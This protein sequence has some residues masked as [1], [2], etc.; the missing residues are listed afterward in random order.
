MLIKPLIV[1]PVLVLI[2]ALASYAPAQGINSQESIDKIVGTPVETKTEKAED[3]LG[4]ILTLMDNSEV[5]LSEV[6]KRTKLDQLEIVYLQDV[7]MTSMPEAI[8]KKQ[9]ERKAEIL[10]LQQTIEGN[11]MFYHAIDSRGILLR[12]ILAIEFLNRDRVVIYAAGNNPG[13]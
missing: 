13:S 4:H 11:A 6:R 8:Q 3:D 7:G 1:A 12:D 10:A 2:S 5:V 9:E